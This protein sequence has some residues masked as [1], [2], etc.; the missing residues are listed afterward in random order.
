MVKVLEVNNLNYGYFK[1]IN[2]AFNKETFYSIVGGNNS[3][4]TTLFKLMTGM[5]SCHNQIICNGVN[6]DNISKYIQNIGVVERVQGNDFIYQKVKD[7]MMYPLYNLG[8]SKKRIE[9]RIKEVTDLFNFN[10]LDQNINELKENERQ[11][12]L[13]MLALLHQPKVLFLDNVFSVF[14]PSEETEILHILKEFIEKEKITI[15]NFSSTLNEMFA[16]DKIILLSN[17]EIIGQYLLNDVYRDDKLFYQ[18]GLEI[19]FIVDLS[20]KLKMYDLIDKNYTNMKAMVDDI[21]P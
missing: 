9:K 8:Y 4:K 14:S 13:I 7:E 18:N 20:I 16:S 1:N 11:L 5:I 15:I 2:L 3:G 12:L 6:T 19:P 17:F 21:W 10:S